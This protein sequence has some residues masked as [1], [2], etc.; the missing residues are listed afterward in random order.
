[1]SDAPPADAPTALM[2]RLPRG[3]FLHERTLWRHRGLLRQMVRADLRSRYVA[4][5]MGFFWSVVHPLLSILVYI[6]VFS[7][8]FQAKWESLGI[9]FEGNFAVYFCCGMLPWIWMSESLSNACQSITSHANLVRKNVFPIVVLPMQGVL[10]ATVQFLIAFAIFLVFR[11]AMFGPPGWE[12]LA[13]P[14]VFVLQFALMTALAYLLA[15]VHVFWR[16]MGQILTSGLMIWLWLTPIFYLPQ[17]IIEPVAR[18][19]GERWASVIQWMFW[20]NPMHH[21]AGLCQRLLFF[22]ATPEGYPPPRLSVIYLAVLCL[23]LWFVAR[24]LFGRAQSRI[25]EMV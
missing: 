14:A 6:F 20:I 11:F 16:D 1:M 24:R 8:I 17:F 2:L 3:S 7:F 5:S 19:W 9:S 10:T 21:L 13:L 15:T 22:T 25:A 4:T 12:A 23:A 18:N